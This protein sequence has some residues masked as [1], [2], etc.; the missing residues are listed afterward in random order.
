[1]RNFA[2]KY[3]KVTKFIFVLVIALR[4]DEDDWGSSGTPEPP[5]YINQM[6]AYASEMVHMEVKWVNRPTGWN[7]V[8]TPWPVKVCEGDVHH[9]EGLAYSYSC[10]MDIEEFN[11]SAN[12]YGPSDNFEWQYW[13]WQDYP[14]GGEDGKRL[15]CH[16]YL[17]HDY[18]SCGTWVNGQFDS[19]RWMGTQCTGLVYHAALHGG[20]T[21]S[22][23]LNDSS[24][25]YNVGYWYNH[26]YDLGDFRVDHFC[27]GN[28]D[29][30]I[31][32]FTDND[33]INAHHIGIVYPIGL[34][35][36]NT[37][38]YHC[39]GLYANPI[40]YKAGCHDLAGIQDALEEDFNLLF[41]MMGD[42][43]R[44]DAS[45]VGWISLYY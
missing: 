37:G 19:T 33:T 32:D 20:F 27:V 5:N 38:I 12:E 2:K 40:K 4:C 14:R 25:K 22:L 45:Y 41:Y 24:L 28:G 42:N 1:M 34:F 3:L 8:Y 18:D 6:L 16:S 23:A 15:G 44:Y 39:L 30:A 13:R 9:D 26:R 31:L 21:F 36:W 10:A 11:S 17:D 43:R 35:E 7:W 29:I